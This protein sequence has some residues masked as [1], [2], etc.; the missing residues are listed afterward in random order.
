[1]KQLFIKRK[2]RRRFR[3]SASFLP[4]LVCFA[5]ALPVLFCRFADHSLPYI[6][7]TQE[8][9]EI[10]VWKVVPYDLPK[11]SYA[12]PFS[13]RAF[14]YLFRGMP[15]IRYEERIYWPY[16]HAI[17][18]SRLQLDETTIDLT[19][20]GKQYL[21]YAIKGIDP[22]VMLYTEDT[23]YSCFVNNND[24]TIRT[25]AD[26][27]ESRIP[28][29]GRYTDAYFSYELPL[30]TEDFYYYG[31]AE[32]YSTFSIKK[33]AYPH[34]DRFLKALN[35]APAL[36]IEDTSLWQR[37]QSGTE[38]ACPLYFKLEN[39]VIV[40]LYLYEGGYVCAENFWG[41]FLPSSPP[42]SLDTPDCP[43]LKKQF[44]QVQSPLRL[45]LPDTLVIDQFILFV[46]PAIQ[47]TDLF[48]DFLCRML[49]GKL[50]HRLKVNLLAGWGHIKKKLLGKSSV[51][52]IGENLLHGLFGFFCD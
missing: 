16:S 49:A 6:R 12:D 24:L 37:F 46:V 13:Y 48:T 35:D 36:R 5:V 50:S 38:R 17:D 18:T 30:E 28:L 2:G 29:L 39:G 1:M 10:P 14:S 19:Y 43:S 32:R 41:R 7:I 33:E 26:L 27:F 3:L 42:A 34:L 25:G 21:A 4:L 44:R 22:S 11:Y 8:G 47:L 52:N 31:N 23:P 15:C 40:I 51:L 9:I 45:N 20:E